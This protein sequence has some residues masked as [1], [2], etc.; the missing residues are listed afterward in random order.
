MGLLDALQIGS[1][2]LRTHQSALQITGNNIA[3]SGT[4]GYSRQEAILGPSGVSNFGTGLTAGGGVELADV[5]RVV[6]MA[7]ESRR[8]QANSHMMQYQVADQALA[9]A[10]SLMNEMTETDVSSALAEFFNSFSALAQSPQEAALRGIALQQATTLTSRLNYVRDGLQQLEIDMT[11]QL[12]GAVVEADRLAEAIAEINLKMIE[13]K[14][15]GGAAPGLADQRDALIGQLSELITVRVQEDANGAANVFIGSEPLVSQTINHGLKLVTRDDGE[16]LKRV[17]AFAHNDGAIQLSGGQ[18][19]GLQSTRD[20]ELK[21]VA[22]RLDTL[23]KQVIWQVNKLHSS[24]TSIAGI[25]NVTGTY[26]VE[27][28]DATL[29]S[30]EAGLVFQP[31]HGSFLLTTVFTGPDGAETITPTR[32][33]VQLTGQPGDA[34]LNSLVAAMDAIANVNASLDAAGKVTLETTN[35]NAIIRLGEDTSGVLA[36]LGINTFFTGRDSSTIAVNEYVSED[37][38]RIA[39]GVSGQPGD[40]S[41]AAAIA[42]LASASVSELAGMSLSEYQQRMVADVAIW[43][44]GAHDAAIANEVVFQGLTAQRESLSGVSMD[45]EAVNLILYQRAF[46]GA[47]RYISVVNEL[48]DTLLSIA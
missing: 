15:G 39:A 2:A 25:Q 7:L 30:E 38:D 41:T 3:N 17:V 16:S 35:S 14:S 1:S 32:I 5:R 33:D 9:R 11:A 4:P 45:E 13:A 44:A 27:D 21:D 43:S 46:Q 26:G 23:A 18:I 6:D 28:A 37:S 42:Q 8:N 36:A 47:A 22:G 24:G 12:E 10:E 48:L 40:G 20:V 34:T 29:N 19:T 31:V